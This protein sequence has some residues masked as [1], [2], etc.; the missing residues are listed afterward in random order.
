MKRLGLFCFSL[1]LSFS[2]YT[3]TPSAADRGLSWLALVD[4]EQYEAS[5]AE[6]APLFKAQVSVK[7]WA[8]TIQKA[9]APFGQLLAREVSGSSEH[10]SLPGAPDGEYVVLSIT[11]QFAH[12]AHA[13]ETLTMKKEGDEWL[14]IG[15]FIQ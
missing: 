15:Y 9:R 10:A 7:Q 4:A 8:E 6:T 3:N 11:S 1:L 14:A 13:I 12:K 2:A 5:W